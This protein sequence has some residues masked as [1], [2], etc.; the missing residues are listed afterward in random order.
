MINY[1]DLS[2]EYSSITDDGCQLIVQILNDLKNEWISECK[3][4]CKVLKDPYFQSLVYTADCISQ[5]LYFA[6][7]ND[8]ED[9]EDTDIYFSSANDWDDDGEYLKIVQVIKNNEPLGVT[10]S[11]DEKTGRVSIARILHDGAAHRSCLINVGDEIHQVN[12]FKVRGKTHYEILNLLERESKMDTVVFKL[13]PAESRN[14]NG[15]VKNNGLIVKAYFDY[16]PMNDNYHPC[17]DIGLSFSKGNILH[18]VNQDDPNWWQ[19]KREIQSLP[20]TNSSTELYSK[21]GIIPGKRLQER[22]FVALRDLKS[23]YDIK[24][25]IELIPGLKSAMKKKYFSR[26]KAKKMMFD[27]YEN[28]NLDKDGILTYEPVVKY[29]PANCFYRPIVLIGPNGIGRKELIRHIISYKPYLYKQPI[30]HTSRSIWEWE[31][32]KFDYYFVS[33]E[34]MEKEIEFGNFVEYGEYN[35]DLYGIH[36]DAI[37]T[38]IRSG[39]V[40]LMNPHP[41]T[42]KVICNAEFKPFVIFIKPPSKTESLFDSR[43]RKKTKLFTENELRDIILNAHKINYLYGH[44]FDTSIVNDDLDETVLSLIKI[45]NSV[46]NQP[47]WVPATW[48]TTFNKFS[49]LNIK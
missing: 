31:I 14:V 39:K 46:E 4:L 28:F 22:R 32:D 25:C 12:G 41:Q 34:F 10:V 44:Y 24:N 23:Q 15:T 42:L 1:D 49:N 16:N 13:I 19:A 20:L 26:R 45:L 2:E 33:R 37:L 18:V 36:R 30:A 3:S 43:N 11:I 38:M 7:D 29:F 27:L 6:Q 9:E 8:E 5:R 47:H 35:G 40:C 21:V 48:T 17:P